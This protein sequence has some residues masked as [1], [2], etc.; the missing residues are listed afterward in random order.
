VLLFGLCQLDGLPSH[1][2][3]LAMDNARTDSAGDGGEHGRKVYM[4]VF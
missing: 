2:G 1:K 4:K 3:Q